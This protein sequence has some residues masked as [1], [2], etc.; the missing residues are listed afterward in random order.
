MSPHDE[1]DR[2]ICYATTDYSAIW[3]LRSWLPDNIGGVMWVAP[4]RPCSSAYTPFYD[5]IT[6]VPA[7]WTSQTGYDAFKAV[8]KS[9]DKKGKVHKEIRYE[10]YIPLVHST[11]G[12]YEADCTCA[13]S[14]IE[15][16]AS[17]MTPANQVAY[18]TN[19]SNQRATQAYNLAVGLPAQMP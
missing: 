3:Q 17:S 16:T 6:T 18:L 5:S 2:P 11:Y 12:A 19:Y 14:G 8:A 1:T 13:Q 15:A 10:Y 9:L 7:E 4:S